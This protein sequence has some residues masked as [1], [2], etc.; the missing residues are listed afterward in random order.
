MTHGYVYLDIQDPL[1]AWNAYRGV[2]VSANVIR[3]KPGSISVYTAKTIRRDPGSSRVQRECRLE[4]IRRGGRFAA[5]SRNWGVY[6]FPDLRSAEL[7][8][9]TMAQPFM[10]AENLVEI[11]LVDAPLVSRHDSNW[12]TYHDC[13]PSEDWI[14]AY[15]RGD[16]CPSYEPVWEQLVGGRYAILGTALR[17]RAGELIR[18]QFPSSMCWLEI[19]RIAAWV[20]SDLGSIAGFLTLSDD[21]H[22][23]LGYYLNLEEWKD[24]A[25][26]DKVVAYMKS[27]LPVNRGDIDEQF[28]NDTFGNVPDF[29]PYQF[30]RPLNEL[31]YLTEML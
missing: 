13:D 28:K 8:R 19:S 24:A 14:E 12:I 2:I 26:S 25:F 11:E 9:G 30:E 23:R 6:T 27:R 5:V 22:L 17:E 7:A 21:A 10:T 29:R 3:N 1:C 31:A 16:Q 15:W 20:G 4:K 18:K